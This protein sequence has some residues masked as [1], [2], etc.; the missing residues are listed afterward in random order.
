MSVDLRPTK[1]Q[2]QTITPSLARDMLIATAALSLAM[3]IA[4]F[5]HEKC[6][7]TTKAR[8]QARGTFSNVVA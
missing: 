3:Y 1:M 2:A 4:L 6:P 8:R 7:S 5:V